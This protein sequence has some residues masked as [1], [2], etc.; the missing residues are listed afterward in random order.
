ML[1]TKYVSALFKHSLLKEH[2]N[3]TITQVDT[4][5]ELAQVDSSTVG[6]IQADICIVEQIHMET[7]LPYKQER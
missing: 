5:S 3:I 2:S 7:V 4:S 1:Y 6:T